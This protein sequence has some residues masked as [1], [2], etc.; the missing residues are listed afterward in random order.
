MSDTTDDVP[1]IDG[2]WKGLLVTTSTSRLPVIGDVRSVQRSRLAIDVTQQGTDLQLRI[3][4]CGIDIETSSRM[5]SMTIPQAFVDS[6]AAVER[7]AHIEIDDGQ[8]RLVVPRI[9]EVQG[10]ELDDPETDRLPESADDERVFDQ[11]GDG[12]PGVTV[13]VSGIIGGEVYVVQKGWNRWRGVIGDGRIRGALRWHQEQSVLDASSRWLR[14][15][16]DSHPTRD[17]QD[18]YFAMQR[19]DAGAE[20]C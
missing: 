10:V 19:R 7:P 13:G 11:D 16:T 9:W 15:D 4:T 14:R 20:G 3:E 18:N 12:H 17:V 8:H 5:V 1:S 6:I 2:H